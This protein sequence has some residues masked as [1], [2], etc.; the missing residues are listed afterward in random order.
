[1]TGES[2][3]WL[4]DSPPQ[5]TRLKQI[6]VTNIFRAIDCALLLRFFFLK[7]DAYRA[8]VPWPA[9]ESAGKLRRR[10]IRDFRAHGRWHNLSQVEG[11]DVARDGAF[12]V[13][14]RVSPFVLTRC[15]SSGFREPRISVRTASDS[16]RRATLVG[17]LARRVACAADI[18]H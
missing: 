9:H 6:D 10:L 3:K 2:L 14:R 16:K 1:M 15:G 5:Q 7:Q 18:T 8:A 4:L 13:T 17:S 11:T 12:D